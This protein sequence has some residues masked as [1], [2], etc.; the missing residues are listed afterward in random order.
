MAWPSERR[1]SWYLGKG[2]CWYHKTMYSKIVNPTI[3]QIICKSNTHQKRSK[4]LVMRFLFVFFFNSLAWLGL[5]RKFMSLGYSFF[6]V[7]GAFM[8]SIL[9]LSKWGNLCNELPP[10]SHQWFSHSF[11]F[12]YYFYILPYLSVH[13]LA[14]ESKIIAVMTS[15]LC[16]AAF[17]LD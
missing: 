13:L 17:P 11:N 14:S 6:W 9:A 1:F 2:F 16:P 12:Y 4:K 8:P 3:I 7:G 10:L 5:G 15:I